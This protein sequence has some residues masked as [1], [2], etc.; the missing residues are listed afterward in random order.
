MPSATRASSKPSQLSRVELPASAS[1]MPA[2]V[3]RAMASSGSAAI[4]I[5]MKTSRPIS[6]LQSRSLNGRAILVCRDLAG[7]G[8]FGVR[9][10][11][12]LIRSSG[13]LGSVS[14]FSSV[15]G[16]SLEERVDQFRTGVK[17]TPGSTQVE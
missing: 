15:T 3:P 11:D 14:L 7:S 12:E 9:L 5:V 2:E 6:Q 17:A 8:Y 16:E 10:G 4:R 1:A 13:Y